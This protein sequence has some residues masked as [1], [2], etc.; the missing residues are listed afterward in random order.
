MQSANERESTPIILFA[1]FADGFSQKYR[2]RPT[3]RFTAFRGNGA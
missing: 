2:V 3:H 1:F